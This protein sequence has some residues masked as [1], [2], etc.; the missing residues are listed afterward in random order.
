[1]TFSECHLCA[2]SHGVLDFAASQLGR[3][4]HLIADCL[5]LFRATHVFFIEQ[6]I[7][8]AVYASVPILRR[9]FGS[10]DDVLSGRLVV[11]PAQPFFAEQ[12]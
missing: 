8:F 10:P 1:M 2:L 5:R 11:T 3:S 12:C 7:S 4:Q 6:M 9:V